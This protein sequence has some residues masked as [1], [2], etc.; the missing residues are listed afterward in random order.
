MGCEGMHD[1]TEGGV[2][3]ALHEVADASGKGFELHAHRV[4]VSAISQ[5]VC[6][7]FNIDPLDLIGSGALL[8]CVDPKQCDAL[9]KAFRGAGIIAANVGTIV[10]DAEKRV[11]QRV[12]GGHYETLVRHEQDALWEALGKKRAD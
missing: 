11:V 10:E 1:P 12:V 5:R 9:L 8:L 3:G 6:K 2:T 4:P 7:H